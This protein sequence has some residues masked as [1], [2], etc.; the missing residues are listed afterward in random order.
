[1][2]CNASQHPHLSLKPPFKPRAVWQTQKRHLQGQP[3]NVTTLWQNQRRIDLWACLNEERKDLVFFRHLW[4]D[5]EV[6]SLLGM[7]RDL[8]KKRERD[9]CMTAACINRQDFLSDLGFKSFRSSSDIILALALFSCRCWEAFCE[10]CFEPQCVSEWVA[11][12]ICFDGIL[13]LSLM[14]RNK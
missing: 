13:S 6:I 8:L 3:I 9:V 11:A 4:R 7:H 10:R 2:T 12:D 1:M 5:E 14:L